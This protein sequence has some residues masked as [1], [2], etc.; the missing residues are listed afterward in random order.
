VQGQVK[1]CWR[2]L[3]ARA[4][5]EQDPAKFLVIV[6]EI[7]VLLELK[8][9]RFKQNGGQL[10]PNPPKGLR[11][12]LCDKAVSLETSKTDENGHAVHEECYVLKMRLKAETSH[13]T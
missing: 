11:C 12:A 5:N 2:E 10:V 8:T 4:V 13:E 1:E 9:G 3:S 6:R 7:N